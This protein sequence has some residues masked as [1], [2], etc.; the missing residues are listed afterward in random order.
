MLKAINAS[1]RS[2]VS[3][4]HV[5]MKGSTVIQRSISA[6]A[7]AEVAHLLY[8]TLNEYPPIIPRQVTTTVTGSTRRLGSYLLRLGYLTPTQLVVALAEQRQRT[9][10]GESWL[11]G[12]LLVQQGV[13]RPQVLTTVLL[14][15]LMDRLLDPG[16]VSPPLLGEYLILTNTVT[17]AQLAPALQLQT[18]LRQRGLQ[19]HLGELLVQQGALDT[20]TLAT[21][22][23]EHQMM[24][25]Q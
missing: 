13:L 25:N 23:R 15:Q 12:D 17:P 16:N 6:A 10:Q 21:I 24:Y 8:K 7:G 11:L 5:A 2:I 19:V 3:A 22:L 20:Q 4:T 18:W 9:A 14:V 1:N